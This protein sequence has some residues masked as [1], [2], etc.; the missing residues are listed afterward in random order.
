MANQ[1]KTNTLVLTKQTVSATGNS[2][3]VNGLEVGAAL[4]GA[5][6][7]TGAALLARD[8]STSGV[9]QGNMSSTGATLGT[10]ITALSGWTRSVERLC[11]SF[12]PP[13]STTWTNMNG[14]QEFFNRTTGNAIYMDLTAYTGV[15]LVVNK[16]ATTGANFSTLYL[17]YNGAFQ[18][19][20]GNYLNLET[21]PV[22]ISTCLQNLVLRSGW[23]SIATAARSG[24]YVALL[25]SGGITTASPIFGRVDAYFM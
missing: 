5:L 1:F 24:V 18:T 16:L 2:L 11:I 25:G 6:S 12:N 15:Q 8:L 19:V 13:G 9:L 10:A 3:Y 22:R 4:S 14:P 17:G 20:P 21:T 23:S 7:S